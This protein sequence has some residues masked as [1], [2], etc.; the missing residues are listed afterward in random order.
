MTSDIP[1]NFPYASVCSLCVGVVANCIVFTAPLPYIAFMVVDF[2]VADNLDSAGYAAGWIAGIFMIGRLISGVPFGMLADTCGRKPCLVLSLFNMAFFGVLFGFST[3]FAIALFTRS[4]C[5]IGNGYMGVVPTVVTEITKSKDHET[6]AFGYVNSAY[7]IGFIVGPVIGGLL[8]RPAFQY[9]RVIARNSLFGLFPYLL[10]SLVC[11]LIALIGM[12]LVCVFVPETLKTVRKSGISIEMATHDDK[13]YG[14]LANTDEEHGTVDADTMS[15]MPTVDEGNDGTLTIC[16]VWT[17]RRLFII[18]M[19]SFSF[20]CFAV[21]VKE[22]FPLW[23]VSSPSRGG[24]EWSAPQVGLILCSVGTALVVFQLL[25]Y[26]PLMSFYFESVPLP[27]VL[28]Y[29][30]VGAAIPIV[31]MPVAQNLVVDFVAPTSCVALYAVVIFFYALH[32][33]LIVTCY[34]SLAMIINA[35]VSPCRRCTLNGFTATASS[36]GNFAAPV[37]GANLFAI[38]DS[39]KNDSSDTSGAD[40]GETVSYIDG[41]LVFVLAGFLLLWL[42]FVVRVKL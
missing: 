37:I 10:P 13:R 23:C 28:H 31:L 11:S 32:N 21:M 16:D 42:S 1:V 20:S 27:Q 14:S 40:G 4:L 17:D 24:L 6:R 25:L 3:N 36:L 18:V 8:A 29:Q 34:S 12:V 2:G 5:G 35:S 9:P 33:V 39:I 38:L 7:G 41:R 30:M 15:A 22:V 19:V 26:Q